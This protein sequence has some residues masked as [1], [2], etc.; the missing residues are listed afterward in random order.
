M[1]LISHTIFLLH[2]RKH[3]YLCYLCSTLPDI[4]SHN[5]Q[6]MKYCRIYLH[7]THRR[8]HQFYN[9]VEAMVLPLAGHSKHMLRWVGWFRLLGAVQSFT[10]WPPQLRI[11]LHKLYYLSNFANEM[12]GAVYHRTPSHVTEYLNLQQFISSDVFVWEFHNVIGELRPKKK[13]TLPYMVLY[14]AAQLPTF[15]S[16][17]PRMTVFHSPRNAAP[18]QQDWHM[19]CNIPEEWRPHWY[20]CTKVHGVTSQKNVSQQVMCLKHM[21]AVSSQFD[22]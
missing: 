6:V 18:K 2:N 8:H 13:D 5:T 10:S 9:E 22:S 7:N 21:P 3:A 15:N 14:S 19:P 1:Q 20:L 11:F 4:Q 16:F 17:G 12:V